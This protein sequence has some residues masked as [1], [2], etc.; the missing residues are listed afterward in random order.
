MRLI[1]SDMQASLD[2]G[3]T[4]HCWC[5][6][7]TRTDGQVFG[8]TDHDRDLLFDELVHLSGSGFGGADLETS[9]GF[10]PDQGEMVGALDSVVLTEADLK[11]GLWSAARIETW[12]V[13]WTSPDLAVKTAI[14]ELGEIRRIDGRFEA[15]ILGLSHKLDAE[16]GHMFTR[17]C[18][19]SL[20][21]PRCTISSAHVDFALGCDKRFSTCRD[22]FANS[23][24]FR[25]FP[26][27]IGNDVLQASPS[28]EPVRDGASRG[29]AS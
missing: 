5:W 13:D 17:R 28:S 7:V 3:V 6:R 27:L 20:G 25:G 2:A 10:A 23:V 14:G 12:R 18:D 9:P 8:F 15:D 29:L 24:N 1:P 26:H 21:D 11:A 4:T 16:M 19:A 22:R